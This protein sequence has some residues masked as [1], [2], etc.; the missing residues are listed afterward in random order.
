V[1][2]TFSVLADGWSPTYA[3]YSPQAAKLFTNECWLQ[4]KAV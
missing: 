1:P 4:V 2:K 3:L